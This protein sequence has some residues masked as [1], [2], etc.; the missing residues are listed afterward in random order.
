MKWK[1]LHSFREKLFARNRG[2][3]IKLN[4]KS[5]GWISP[6]GLCKG[7]LGGTVDEKNIDI[8]C[9]D[10]S[11]E[12]DRRTNESAARIYGTE[13]GDLVDRVEALL[14]KGMKNDV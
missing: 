6:T 4:A 2:Q 8:P 14:K 9:A 3:I 13:Y 12:E 10:S 11:E 7:G 1:L 5:G